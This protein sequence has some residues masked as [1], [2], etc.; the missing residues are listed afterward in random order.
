MIR[1]I[2][3]DDHRMVRDGFRRIIEGHPDMTLLDEAGDGDAV[4]SLLE[5]TEP[6]VLVLDISMPG[7]GFPAVM[8]RIREDHPE[9]P[10]LVV[11]MHEEEHWAVG[12]F[13]LGAK[14]FLTKNHS[15]EELAE[16]IRR[17]HSGGR[18]VTP[19]V[20][21]AL[22]AQVG[23]GEGS[24]PHELLSPREQEVLTLLGSG[25]MVK[26]VAREMGLSPKT[27]STYRARILEKLNLS[28]TAEII[29]YAVK[30]ELV[31]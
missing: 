1:L 13:R 12:A 4:L 9:L 23:S 10:V 27:V 29:Q 22:A 30:H 17:V 6:D 15:A 25:K 24:L 19:A 8:A 2:I 28:S 20:A 3:G 21:E 5:K 11:S 7:P 14:G 31:S 16:A 18:Y 26:T